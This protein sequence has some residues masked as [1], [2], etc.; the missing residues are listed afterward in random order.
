MLH[1]H[2]EGCRIRQKT[3]EWCKAQAEVGLWQLERVSNSMRDRVGQDSKEQAA[4]GE[5]SHAYRLGLGS[6][7][8]L[9]RNRGGSMPD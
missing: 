6:A 2:D 5:S 3:E 1:L 7:G 8:R 4:H 9:N